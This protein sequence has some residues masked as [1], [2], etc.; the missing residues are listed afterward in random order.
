M[1]EN[2][3]ATLPARRLNKRHEI[4][5]AEEWAA[6]IER[7]H[8]YLLEEAIY[9]PAALILVDKLIENL[10]DGRDI[11]LFHNGQLPKE[12]RTYTQRQLGEML[13]ISHVAVGKRAKRGAVLVGAAVPSLKGKRKFAAIRAAELEA[14][15]VEDL[16]DNVRQL[17]SA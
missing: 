16:R 3:W 15:G 9:D 4:V 5:E 12:Q 1:S 8:K 13:G 14:R 2:P 6:V 17:R 7:F 10:Q 11:V